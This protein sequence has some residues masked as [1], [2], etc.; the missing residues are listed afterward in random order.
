MRRGSGFS[1]M[2]W[3]PRGGGGGGGGGG[4]GGNGGRGGR[5]LMVTLEGGNRTAEASALSPREAVGAVVTAVTSAGRRAFRRSAGEGLASQNMAAVRITLAPGESLQEV[6]VR[7]PS[8]RVTGHRPKATE[9]AVVIR[10]V[11]P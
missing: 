9:S 10:E 2:G 11:E 7:W 4:N 5:V 3:G 6:N 8:G 1:L